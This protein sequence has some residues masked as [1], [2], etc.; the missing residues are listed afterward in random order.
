MEQEFRIGFALATGI[1]RNQFGTS[2]LL[3]CQ[4][5]FLNLDFYVL[6]YPSPLCFVASLP[7]G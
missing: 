1:R 6:E 2:A 7:F 4:Y 5:F 3:G